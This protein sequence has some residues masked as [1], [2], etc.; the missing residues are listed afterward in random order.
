MTEPV[1]ALSNDALSREVNELRARDAAFERA[2][3]P[4]AA[5][6]IGV[7]ALV[8]AIVT[9]VTAP[10][11][12][13][14]IVERE[15]L[16]GSTARARRALELA[17]RDTSTKDEA[18]AIG[19]SSQTKALTVANNANTRLR[20]SSST[21]HREGVCNV[22]TAGLN[23]YVVNASDADTSNGQ[24]PYC[25]TCGLGASFAIGGTD[26]ARTSAGSGTV[27][28][29]FYDG[30]VGGALAG[31]GMSLG[32]AS[33]TFL[34]RNGSNAASSFTIEN[35][36]IDLLATEGGGGSLTINT[37]FDV[38]AYCEDDFEA[39]AEDD[40]IIGA[41]DDITLD[42][43]T[44]CVDAPTDRVG[45]G[46]CAPDYALHVS[47]N[48]DAARYLAVSNNSAGTSALAGLYVHNGSSGLAFQRR[49]AGFATLPDSNVL[50]GDS[51]VTG[52]TLLTQGWNESTPRSLQLGIDDGGG[53]NGFSPHI[54]M[55]PSNGAPYRGATTFNIDGDDID[56]LVESDTDEDALAVDG[57]TGTVTHGGCS[58]TLAGTLSCSDDLVA[59]DDAII[60]GDAVVTGQVAATGN[61]GST[62]SVTGPQVTSGTPGFFQVHRLL[63]AAAGSLPTC[64]TSS[65]AAKLVYVD[66]TDDATRARFCLCH[67]NGSNAYSWVDVSD[68]TTACAAPS[69]LDERSALARAWEWMTQ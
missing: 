59:T 65:D 44:F 1:S 53:T 7:T 42:S 52:G 54:T 15:R 32:A 12:D 38:Y 47:Q 62:T 13:V 50:R 30:P 60:G 2:C 11:R 14:V 4:W 25:D 69:A 5:F 68:M 8:V 55:T 3:A 39:F 43:A 29:R 28:C 48:A 18:R 66:D 35:T 22:E 16:E 63:S 31:G 40:V 61:V 20:F 56:F 36:N 23:V 24:G 26:Y 27:R 10:S 45:V 64:A 67:A 34:E 33:N 57:A 58:S 37:R 6:A 41:L 46:T 19:P 17:R 49:G 9:A 51:G 21:T